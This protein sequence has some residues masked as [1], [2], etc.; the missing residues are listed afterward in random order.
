MYFAGRFTVYIHSDGWLADWLFVY[1][2]RRQQVWKSC[3][4]RQF[5]AK[6][7]AHLRKHSC[8]KNMR[9]TNF[10]TKTFALLRT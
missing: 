7:P 10:S 6:L 9:D 4:I 8:E 3:F 5:P 1:S 2:K